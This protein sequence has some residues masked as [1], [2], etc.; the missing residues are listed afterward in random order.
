M[1]QK[2]EF[3]QTKSR[4]L[5]HYTSS[6]GLLGILGSGS[7]HASHYGFLND[8]SEGG[9]LRNL[10]L[11]QL[12][13]E[14]RKFVPHLIDAGIIKPELL[15]AHGL[16]YYRD[17]VGRMFDSMATATNNVA[18]YFI[19]SFCMHEDGTDNHAN[20]LLSQWRGYARG[21]FAIEFDEFGIDELTKRENAECRLQGIL[22]NNVHYRDF[23]KFVKTEQFEGFAATLFK[24]VLEQV[25]PKARN[26]LMEILGDKTTEDFAHAY[27]SAVPFLKNSGFEEESEYRIVALCNRIGVSDEA[28]QRRYKDMH[29]RTGRM[30]ELRHSSNF[31]TV[32]GATFPSSQLS[33]VRIPIRRAKLR[34]LTSSLVKME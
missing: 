25:L 29:F 24:A 4:C 1:N 32:W 5:F 27:L 31:L 9:A 15:A 7:L 23:E 11:P 3:D 2:A 16:N 19:T 33:L 17:E 22:T 21:G 13:C 12:E 6:E 30:G 20:G 26:K 10:L 8:K 18:P 34:W 28:D 14:T